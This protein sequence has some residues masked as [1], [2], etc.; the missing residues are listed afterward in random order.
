[1]PYPEALV[2]YKVIPGIITLAYLYGVSVRNKENCLNVIK[3]ISLV[4]DNTV[5]SSGKPL[6]PSLALG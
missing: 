6:Q 5:I 1:L 2:G 4:S 3:L